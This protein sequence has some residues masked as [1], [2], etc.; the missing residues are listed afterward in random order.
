MTFLTW[1]F[2]D[3]MWRPISGR[4]WVPC[5]MG[6]LY[7]SV[8]GI[9]WVGWTHSFV[10]PRWY[11]LWMTRPCQPTLNFPV[12]FNQLWQLQTMRHD[13]KNSLHGSAAA[14]Q[15]AEKDSVKGDVTTPHSTSPPRAFCS[16]RQPIT[17]YIG[18]F[19]EG[20][21]FTL[22]KD[23]HTPFI[24]KVS[25]QYYCLLSVSFPIYCIF[26]VLH[27]LI[28]ILRPYRRYA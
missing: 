24:V 15:S 1:I 21:E 26:F 11:G 16:Y 9:A 22:S 6:F 13:F 5:T 3:G 7:L 4:K 8:A 10:W 20:Q 12:T 19:M 27:N 25:I 23:W 14:S 18:L 17:D 2:Q 28:S